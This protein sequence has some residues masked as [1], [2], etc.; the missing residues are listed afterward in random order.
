MCLSGYSRRHTL[1]S[2]TLLVTTNSLAPL[3]AGRVFVIEE[4]CSMG[5]GSGG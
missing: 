2:V 4:L 1:S 3:G 5:V